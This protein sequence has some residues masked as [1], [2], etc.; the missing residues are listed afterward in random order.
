MNVRNIFY[1]T[2]FR[3]GLYIIADPADNSITLSKRLFRHIDVMSLD[4]AKVYVFSIPGDTPAYAFTIN[5]DFSQPTQL[6][7]IQYN[8]KHR[9][10]GFETLCPTV[11]RIFY[12]YRLP[13]D[14]PCKLSVTIRQTAGIVYYLIRQPHNPHK[15]HKAYYA[16]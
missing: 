14:C 8:S 1:N 6:C 2:I 9:C 16:Y 10:I 7:D 3:R 15:P 12:D 13:H 11:N 5:P 4:K